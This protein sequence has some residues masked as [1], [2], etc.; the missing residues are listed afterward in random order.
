MVVAQII[1]ERYRVLSFKRFD[2]GAVAK[3]RGFPEEKVPDKWSEYTRDNYEAF[4][5]SA[6]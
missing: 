2:N 5:L 1:D 3:W 4:G 6:S